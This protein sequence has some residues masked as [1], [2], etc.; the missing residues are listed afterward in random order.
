MQI[1][2][3]ISLKPYNTFGIDAIAKHYISVKSIEELQSVLKSDSFPNKFILGGGSNML[4]TKDIEDLVVHV[5]LKGIEVV[6][7]NDNHIFVKANAC[8]LYTSDAADE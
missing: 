3:N 2:K 5:N 1:Q 8:L 4:L 7:E 6:S